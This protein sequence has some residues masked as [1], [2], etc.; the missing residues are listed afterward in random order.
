MRVARSLAG[1]TAARRSGRL[2]GVIGVF[3]LLLLINTN[4]QHCPPDHGIHPQWKQLVHLL[5][6]SALSAVDDPQMYHDFITVLYFQIQDIPE[7][8]FIDIVTSR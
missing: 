8:F 3:Q 4:F 2:P 6:S 7:D 1:L 5:C